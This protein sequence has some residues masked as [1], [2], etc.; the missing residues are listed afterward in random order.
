M[1]LVIYV[2]F[3]PLFSYFCYYL[4]IV[5]ITSTFDVQEFIYEPITFQ[6][7]IS[8]SLVCCF[9]EKTLVQSHLDEDAIQSI[10]FC[11]EILCFYN[12]TVHLSN[13]RFATV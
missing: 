8:S 10:H 3:L 5:I 9:M 7:I 4:S 6:A 11:V 2:V 12:L 13:A 1:Q